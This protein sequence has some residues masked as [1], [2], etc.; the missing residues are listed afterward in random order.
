LKRFSIAFRKLTRPSDVLEILEE[1]EIGVVPAWTL[2][3]KR[4]VDNGVAT[5]VT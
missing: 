5:A 4:P 1:E 3:L 2:L